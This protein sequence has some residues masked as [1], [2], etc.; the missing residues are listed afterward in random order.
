MVN[1][2]I[3]A[4]RIAQ[5]IYLIRGQKVMLD[6][7][8]AGFYGVETKQLTRQVR[9]NRESFPDDFMFAL[10]REEYNSLRRQFGALEGKGRYSKYLPYAFTELGVAMISSVLKSRNARQ[11]NI[12]IVRT[13]VKLREYLSTHRQ[14]AEKIQK[15]E[16]KFLEHDKR[17]VTIYELIDKLMSNKKEQSKKIQI[18]FRPGVEEDNYV[19]IYGQQH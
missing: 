11:I 4:E 1:I 6:N 18:G 16:N 15:I 8:L 3:P 5:K 14:V 17:L 10:T 12:V 7:D 13:F 2:S 9:R 19:A